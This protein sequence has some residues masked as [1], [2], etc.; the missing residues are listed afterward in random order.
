[1]RNRYLRGHAA[2]A[3]LAVLLAVALIAPAFAVAA[4][5]D[6]ESSA[7]ALTVGASTPGTLTPVAGSTS[8]YHFVYS[9]ALTA[10][11]TLVA[12]YTVSPEVA[13]PDLLAWAAFRTDIAWVGS[14]WVSPTVRVARF[15]A[16][17]TGAYYLTAFGQSSPGTFTIDSALAPAVNYALSKLTAPSKAKKRKAFVISSTLAGAFDELNIPVNFVITRPNSAGKYKTFKTVGASLASRPDK[18][19]TVFTA[20]LRLAA[21]TYQV[22]AEFKDA[23]HPR[24]LKNAARKIVVK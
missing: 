16:P 13:N 20:S 5:G 7:V 21:G 19:H 9:V 23:A 10:G 14:S 3:G 1:M 24:P 15:L 4:P 18:R 17:K 12:T 22:H 8:N 6:G 11:Q 2:A